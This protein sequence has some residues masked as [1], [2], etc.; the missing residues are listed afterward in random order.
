VEVQ[1][2]V[3]LVTGGAAGIGRATA[4]RLARAG[5][6]VV[7]ADVDASGGEET[8]ALIRDAGGEGLFLRC[9]VA[10]DEEV[11]DLIAGTERAHGGLEIVHNNAGVLSGPRFPDEEQRYWRRALDI[12]LGGVLSVIYHA[13]PVMRRR[14]GVIVNTAS[15]AGLVPH[16]VDPVYAATKAGVLNLTRSLTFLERESGIRVNCICPGFVATEIEEHSA[17]ALAEADRTGFRQRRARMTGAPRLTPEQVAEAVL[18][19]I[20]DDSLNGRAY[21]MVPGEPWELL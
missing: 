7:V 16:F 10:R 11:A 14:G 12:N 2:R 5:A 4:L 19:L 15:I 1:D 20:S 17:A 8:A 9:D 6:R 18:T 13:V 21:R 3:A